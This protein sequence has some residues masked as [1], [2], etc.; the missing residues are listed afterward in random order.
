MTGFSADGNYWRAR[1]GADK[2]EMHDR[3][4]HKSVLKPMIYASFATHA[5]STDSSFGPRLF[6]FLTGHAVS[7]SSRL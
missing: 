2:P 6:V 7:L 1:R 4:N 5:E 3:S